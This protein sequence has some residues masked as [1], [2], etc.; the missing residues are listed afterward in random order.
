MSGPRHLARSAR[1]YGVAVL[2]VALTVLLRAALDASFSER[3]ILLLFIAPILLSAYLGGLGPGLLAT[4]LAAAWTAVFVVEPTGSPRFAAPVDMFLWGLLVVLGVLISFLNEALHRAVRREKDAQQHAAELLVQQR[5]A[6]VRQMEADRFRGFMVN[7]PIGIVFGDAEGHIHYANDEYLRI[8][9]QDRSGLET[10]QARWDTVTP[11]EWLEADRNATAALKDTPFV[12]Y[13]KE[14]L[15]P[16]GT[17]VPVMIGLIPY[18][19]AY[20]AFVLDVSRERRAE[21]ELLFFKH[22]AEFTKEPFY[23][24]DP[25]ADFRFLYVNEAACRH[26]GRSREELLNLGIHDLDPLFSRDRCVRFWQELKSKRTLTFETVHRH[27]DG[28]EIEVEVSTTLFECE[29]RELFAGWFHHISE[30]KSVERQLRESEEKF[31]TVAENARAVF[32][33]VQGDRFVYANRYLMEASGYT[34]EEIYSMPFLYLV[35]PAHRAMVGE[36]AKRRL[37]GKPAPSQY[38]FIMLTKAGGERWIDLTV[39]AIEYQGK[40]AIIGTGFDVTDRKRAETALRDSEE[41]LRLAIESAKLLQWEYESRTGLW[42]WTNPDPSWGAGPRTTATAEEF[43]SLMHPDDRPRVQMLLQEAMDPSGSGQ[44]AAEFRFLRPDGQYRWLSARGRIFFEGGDGTRRPVRA[45]GVSVD[46]TEQKAGQEMLAAAKEAAENARA[47]AEDASRAKDRFLAVLS[48]ELRTPLTPVLASVSMLQKQ[49]RL[50]SRTQD[51]LEMIRRNIE[52]EA[53]LIDDML[54]LTGIVRGKIE[55]DKKPIDLLTVVNRA[56]EV[57]RPDIQARGLEFKIHV[58]PGSY[59]VE[60]D[61]GRLQQV[62]WNIL[63]NSI[64]FTPHGGRVAMRCQRDTSGWVLIEVDDSGVGLEPDQLNHIFDAFA[65]ADP[66][67]TRRFGGLGLGLAIS[68]SLV[69]LHGGTIEAFSPGKDRGACFQIRL[70]SLVSEAPAAQPSWIQYPAA[71]NATAV[72]SCRILV[73]EDHG[74]TAE[75]LQRILELE[76]HEVQTA[77]D[78]ATAVQLVEERG[79]DLL[80]S[81]LGLPD[82]SGLDLLRKLRAGGKKLP[83]IALS[84]YGQ[85]QDLQQTR[86][87]GFIAHVVKPVDIERLLATVEQVI[88]RPVTA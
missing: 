65:Q 7:A 81:D 49:H 39:S 15:R 42:T 4:G 66:S 5:E 33:I 62:F 46:V 87:A 11:A 6:E 31:R 68:R 32:G 59:I 83:A 69:E 2:L 30:R 38:E 45:L 26:F 3:P 51:D 22:L 28:H 86:D 64:K 50:D 71:A 84:G 53:R 18:D 17:R 55:L 44:Y 12:R 88:S 43:M 56:V 13:E 9:G 27:A 75:M 35:H 16:D 36:R 14:Y 70:P 78:L 79:F 40:P 57:C 47:I 21:K 8:L 58:E 24:V 37:M 54:D 80:I 73:V 67:I 82:G 72:R 63:K 74:D 85:E 61:A 41:R 76:G 19:S 1:G 20:A 52:L 25:A 60:G 48:H 10:G 77:G 23:A 34:L 29:G